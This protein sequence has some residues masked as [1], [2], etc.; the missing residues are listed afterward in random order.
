MSP[1]CTADVRNTILSA[2]GALMLDE[3]GQ[4]ATEPTDERRRP[5]VGGVGLPL[6]LRR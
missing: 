1:W 5:T 3:A 4:S 2:A 6:P